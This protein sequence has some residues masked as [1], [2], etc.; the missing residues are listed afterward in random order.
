MLDP[1]LIRLRA[2]TAELQPPPPAPP[3]PYGCTAVGLGPDNL[4]CLDLSLLL[5]YI[6]FLAALLYLY[7]ARGFL[8]SSAVPR[9]KGLKASLL[10]NG[11]A[12]GDGGN[13][14]ATLLLNDGAEGGEGGNP[15]ESGDGDAETAK[16]RYS[17]LERRLR[18]LFHR[19][20]CVGM[21][22]DICLSA[23]SLPFLVCVDL[24]SL[25]FILPSVSC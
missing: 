20:V 3:V 2:L 1:C 9:W 12:A 6:F 18:P 17:P 11:S 19:L 7:L 24:L 25:S 10:G 5:L 23:S 13:A 22:C 14:S 16:G 8:S 4:S 15:R 21:L